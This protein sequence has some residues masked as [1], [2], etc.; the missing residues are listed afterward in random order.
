MRT[1][2]SERGLERLICTALASH[3]CEPLAS[4]TLV[5]TGVIDRTVDF[6]KRNVGSVAWIDGACRYRKSAFPLDAVQEA[7]VNAVVHQD[8]AREGTDIKV[9]LYKD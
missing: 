6:V 5:G 8:Y 7:V 2:T 4:G 1:D 3:P 9:S